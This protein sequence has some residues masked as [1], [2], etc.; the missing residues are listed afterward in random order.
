MAEDNVDN[1][2]QSDDHDDKSQAEKKYDTG[3]NPYS[4]EPGQMMHESVGDV[5]DVD[6]ALMNPWQRL[7]Y[8]YAMHKTVGRIALAAVIVAV[9]GLA[10]GV[11]YAIR[12]QH[13]AVSDVVPKRSWEDGSQNNLPVPKIVESAG[14][15]TITTIDNEQGGKSVSAKIVS[16]DAEGGES[17]ATL[18]PP[19]DLRLVGYYHRS[20]PFGVNKGSSLMTAHINY[21][22]ITGFGAV[23][24]SLKKG[25]PITVNFDG[26]DT[27]YV[28][29]DNPQHINK[30]SA[31]YVLKT[32]ETINKMS[33]KNVLVLVTCGGRYLGDNSPLGYE[34]N[35]VVVADPVEDKG[36][37]AVEDFTGGDNK[38]D[39]EKKADK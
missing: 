2:I 36:S 4:D 32:T 26:K 10:I 16:I 15:G 28:V 6:R 20:A 8:W 35:V 38:S 30:S 24:T 11:P 1:N 37:G 23:F 5:V 22:G 29:R 17:G 3:D 27:R 31:D 12:V 33:G 19:E 7:L 34:D 25:D 18:V 13:Q 39:A 9:L 14:K 21:N